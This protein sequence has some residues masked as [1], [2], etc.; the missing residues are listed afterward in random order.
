MSLLNRDTA[1]LPSV[2]PQMM[3]GAASP[4]WALFAGATF[5][6]MAFWWS[7]RLFAP[8]NLE[9]LLDAVPLAAL[10]PAVLAPP[11]P[12]VVP[13]EAPEPAF[14]EPVA[15]EAAPAVE[16]AEAVVQPTEVVV[17]SGDPVT[18]PPT[19]ARTKAPKSSPAV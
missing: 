13:D 12:V 11:E 15:V 19:P 1:I 18:S 16:V 9:A 14:E 10:T 8:K 17:Q 2:T 5:S 4:L 3:V 6:G 7:A